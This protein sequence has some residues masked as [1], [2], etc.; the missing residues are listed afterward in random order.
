[1]RVIRIHI[2]TKGSTFQIWP[3][4]LLTWEDINLARKTVTGTVD[5]DA[6]CIGA[7][8]LYSSEED[9]YSSRVFDNPARIVAEEE[10]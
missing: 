6:N 7:I 9:Y 8:H 3:E 10:A 4:R 2:Y 1:M 5:I